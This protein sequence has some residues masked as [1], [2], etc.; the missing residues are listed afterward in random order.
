[1]LWIQEL[2]PGRRW[3]VKKHITIAVL[4]LLVVFSTTLIVTAL[5][6]SVVQPKDVTAERQLITMESMK[7]FKVQGGY[8]QYLEQYSRNEGAFTEEIPVYAQDDLL[9]NQSSEI[10]LPKDGSIELTLSGLRTGTDGMLVRY[11]TKAIR[12]RNDG[13]KYLIYDMD[14]GYRLFLFL[15]KKWDYMG[16]SGY[17]LLIGEIREYKEYKTLSKGDPIETVIKIDPLT[18]IY[19]QY[20]L[21]FWK[22]EPISA[23]NSILQ[24]DPLTSMHYLKDGLLKITY[25]MEEPGQLI[26]YDIQYSKDRIFKDYLGEPVDYTVL[27]CDLPY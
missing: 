18:K 19:K 17:P 6:K 15:E 16:Y 5:N 25:T 27:E 24:N 13:A 12:S 4:V 9:F 2:I 8:K 22:W 7:A 23:Q 3:T 26:I 1:M 14:S 11:P 21:D 20:I 10:W